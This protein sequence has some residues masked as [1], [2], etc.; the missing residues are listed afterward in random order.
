MICFN[1]H[2]IF[3]SVE[4]DETNDEAHR[5][6]E[7]KDVNPIQTL[8][9]SYHALPEQLRFDREGRVIDGV[10][11][12]KSIKE[13]L[14]SKSSTFVRFEPLT[15]SSFSSG[16]YF[17]HLKFFLDNGILEETI[18]NSVVLIISKKS[19]AIF[20][21]LNNYVGKSNLVIA[22]SFLNQVTDLSELSTHLSS[23]QVRIFYLDFFLKR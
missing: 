19:N 17:S 13:F 11:V 14:I 16:P 18:T 9:S 8:S 23:K 22:S 1:S 3:S 10:D 5:F 15:T 6:E 21:I 7:N 20:V 12:Y 4:N 2:S